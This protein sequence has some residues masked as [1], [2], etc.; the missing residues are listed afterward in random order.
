MDILK[1]CNDIKQKLESSGWEEIINSYIDSPEFQAIINKLAQDVNNNQ[2]F[3]PKMGD[4]FNSFINCNFNA[5]NVIFINQDPYPWINV[6]DGMA[7]SCSKDKVE[8]KTLKYIFDYIETYLDD[9]SRNPDLKRWSEQGVLL[10]NTSITT[11]LNKL[12]S[13]ELLWKPFITYILSTIN[14]KRSDLIVVMFGKKTEVWENLLNNQIIL[15][16]E[17][18]NIAAYKGKWDGKNIFD[19]VNNL[20]KNQGKNEIF[21]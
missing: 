6:A 17:H 3:T 12:G 10:L 19:E 11:E 9:Y 13:H 18:P 21:W 1:K 20:L 4:W 14:N 2:R 7:F 16:V 8:Q 5:L 15:K